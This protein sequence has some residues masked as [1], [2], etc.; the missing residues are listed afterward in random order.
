MHSVITTSQACVVDKLCIELLFHKAWQRVCV[1]AMFQQTCK[2]WLC[3]DPDL[4]GEKGGLFI[5]SSKAMHCCFTTLGIYS[6]GVQ[7]G[8]EWSLASV[9]AFTHWS[10]M[11]KYSLLHFIQAL[12]L[13]R[14]L[15]AT[16]LK[17]CWR[18]PRQVFC[19]SFASSQLYITSCTQAE[20]TAQATPT[21]GQ[22]GDYF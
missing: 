12:P 9:D 11:H 1:W 5:G 15:W 14:A 20:C 22:R 21:V 8:A 13:P 17:R 16:E 6:E 2:C 4:A 7:G 19:S 18:A 10:R 3:F